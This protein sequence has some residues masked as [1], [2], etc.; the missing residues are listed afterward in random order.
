MVRHL[1]RRFFG[2]VTARP[3][4]PAEQAAVANVLSPTLRSL[5][6]SQ[7]VGDQRHAYTVAARVP[8]HLREAAL[9]H[10]VGKVDCGLG[11]IQRS[12][13]TVYAWLGLPMWGRW[14]CYLNHGRIGA[15][16]IEAAGGSRMAVQFALYHPGPTP[17]GVDR[18]AWYALSAAD[19]R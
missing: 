1:I 9:L 13:A 12:L 3:L 18:D 14:E 2:H 16:R 8:P 6:Y 10:D 4:S 5:F 11:A 17:E 7:A 19:D 15:R